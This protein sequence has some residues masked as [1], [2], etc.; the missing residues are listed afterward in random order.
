MMDKIAETSNLA[1]RVKT[2]KE[3]NFGFSLF[4]HNEVKLYNHD[5]NAFQLSLEKSNDFTEDTI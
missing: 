3:I 1:K 4:S 5:E 2:L